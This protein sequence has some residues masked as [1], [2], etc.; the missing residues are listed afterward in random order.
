MFNLKKCFLSFVIGGSLLCVSA[1]GLAQGSFKTVT[2]NSQV[3]ISD[4]ELRAFAK[5]YVENQ[6][7]RQQYE[8]PLKNVTDPEKSKQIQDQA[9]RELKKSL[10]KQNL[11]IEKYNRIYNQLNSDE[12]LRKKALKLIDEERQRLS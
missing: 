11:S 8:P 12:R 7:I 3:N 9:N 6:K 10:A 1:L 5:A 2:D 4:G